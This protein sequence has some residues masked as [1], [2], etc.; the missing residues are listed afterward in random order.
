MKLGWLREYVLQT[1]TFHEPMHLH[2]FQ[3]LLQYIHF[4][5]N[6]S[7]GNDGWRKLGYS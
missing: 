4:V 5:N 3:L 2:R 6:E 1:P 7:I